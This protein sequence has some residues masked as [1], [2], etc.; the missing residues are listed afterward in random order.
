MIPIQTVL[1]LLAVL[2]MFG[3]SQEA[4][5]KLNLGGPG[6]TQTTGTGAST[7]NQQTAG[8]ATP[9]PTATPEQTT[10]GTNTISG[11]GPLGKEET[12]LPVSPETTLL[13]IDSTDPKNLV[14]RLTGLDA[15]RLFFMTGV[16]ARLD[17]VGG[18]QDASA[19]AEG[20]AR[21]SV[22]TGRHYQ[23]TQTMLGDY[24]CRITVARGTGEIAVLEDKPKQKA[25]RFRADQDLQG[26]FIKFFDSTKTDR[27]Y[28]QLHLYNDFAKQTYDALSAG[29]V[30]GWKKGK[31]VKCER[32]A[33]LEANKAEAY[34]C[35]F[36][37]TLD[38][39]HIDVIE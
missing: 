35:V 2:L 23:C 3:C 15:Y 18:S 1:A 34:H 32:N 24:E 22:K 21:A 17:R 28:F 13:V 36:Y 9:T 37:G 5:P 4:P 14:Y 12:K 31:H 11:K 29:E 33:Q 6:T 7:G 38:D 27:P 8:T 25:A 30:G 39:G 16:A 10:G 20:A 26:I 19:E